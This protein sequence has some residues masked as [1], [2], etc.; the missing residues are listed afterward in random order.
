MKGIIL[1]ALFCVSTSLVSHQVHAFGKSKPDAPVSAV[2]LTHQNEDTARTLTINLLTSENPKAAFVHYGLAAA[3]EKDSNLFGTYPHFA[4]AEKLNLWNIE[5][6]VFSLE[7]KDL[8]PGTTF[9][10]G[11]SDGVNWLH[12][13]EKFETLPSDDSPIRFVTGGDMGTSKE[14]AALHKHAAA[15]DPQI[16][17]IGGDVAY[18]NGRVHDYRKW[19]EWLMT[20][21]R[22][23]R[24][25]GGALIPL[26]M[27][28]GNHEVRT[29]V[30]GAI[31]DAPFYFNYFP[32]EGTR[33]FFERRL[34]SH[35]R[36]Y[37]LDTGHVNHI[38]G[39]QTKWLKKKIS[40][41][42]EVPNRVALY[43]VPLFPSVRD[44]MSI[45]SK[46]ARKHWLPVFERYRLTAGFENHDHALKRT[47]PIKNGMPWIEGPVFFGDGC[48]GRT[49]RGVDSGRIYLAHAES[50]RHFWTVEA[51]E[52]GLKMQALDED[53]GI[54]DQYTITHRKRSPAGL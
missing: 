20:W 40:Q 14:V 46:M 35:T 18:A 34:G 13:N 47:W 5:R 23:M 4:R 29:A 30:A 45:L 27:A 50:I 2:Y 8:Q 31:E 26:V 37:I 11:I 48:W 10:F 49:P 3:D 19:D 39:Y 38:F 22:E 28:I 24:R 17:L 6:R 52:S 54:R 43:H 42:Q 32:Q 1:L 25:P 7:L 15:T 53:G 9:Y 21:F 33:S 41:D 16:A 12:F 51:S 44:E 36:L